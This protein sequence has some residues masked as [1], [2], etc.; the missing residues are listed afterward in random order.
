[1]SRGLTLSQRALAQPKAFQN[2]ARGNWPRSYQPNC[3]A[4]SRIL[5]SRLMVER[6]STTAIQHGRR[7]RGDAARRSG[8]QRP[9]AATKAAHG[10]ARSARRAQNRDISVDLERRCKSGLTLARPTPRLTLVSRD[11]A[12]SAIASGASTRA[13]RAFSQFSCLPSSSRH[14]PLPPPLPIILFS[15]P[16]R[17]CFGLE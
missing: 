8:T 2:T 14:I 6:W 13:S 15:R 10:V 9:R 16:K 3:F 11:V 4:A 12:A 1:M 7:R 17:V 5:A